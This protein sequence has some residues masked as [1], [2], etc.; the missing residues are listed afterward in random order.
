MLRILIAL[1]TFFYSL[2]SFADINLDELYALGATAQEGLPFS[3]ECT[4]NND[5]IRCNV[6]IKNGSYMEH[7]KPYLSS[8]QCFIN[9]CPNFSHNIEVKI[10]YDK[11]ICIKDC[12]YDELYKYEY[13]N[14]CYKA[15]PKGSHSL[16]NNEY[17][18]KPNVYE[19]I[20]EYPFLIS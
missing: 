6:L 11:Q 15:C 12:Y 10:I 5:L 3:A 14:F 16:E 17:I 2:S 7:L 19:C 18:C 20:E 8:K 4:L 13:N 9:D 1:L